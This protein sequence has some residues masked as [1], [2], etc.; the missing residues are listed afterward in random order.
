MLA[1]LAQDPA[2]SLDV[3]LVELAISRR[4]P[5]RIHQ[6]LALQKADLGDGHVRELLAQ[7]GQDV[8]DGQV[9]PCTHSAIPRR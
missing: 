2:Q 9:G 6:T 7:Q 4:G 5:L 8:T 3:V 1:L